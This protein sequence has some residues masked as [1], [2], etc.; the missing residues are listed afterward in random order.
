MA[1]HRD[2]EKHPRDYL[3]EDRSDWRDPGPLV[4]KPGSREARFVRLIAR[5]LGR[6]IAQD[7]RS[8]NQIA[9]KA[10]VSPQTI[11]NILDGKTWGDAPTIWRLEGA[12]QE[13]LWVNDSLEVEE[14]DPRTL[15]PRARR[16][17]GG[18]APIV[19]EKPR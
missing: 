5:R 8:I 3:P 17:G 2:L 1:R 4:R 12:L 14:T 13:R 16:P 19:P 10:N 9:K 11:H 7:G 18:T 6:L 15:T